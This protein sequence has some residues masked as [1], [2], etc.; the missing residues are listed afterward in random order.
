MYW[1]GI[2]LVLVI[3]LGAMDIADLLLLACL[4]VVSQLLLKSLTVKEAL[5]STRPRV[6]IM[7][8][9]SFALGS[10]LQNTGIA[11][12]VADGLVKATLS[13]G[14]CLLAS[15]IHVLGRRMDPGVCVAVRAGPF[16]VLL[17]INVA[18]SIVNGVI[19]NNACMVL[20]FPICVRVRLLCCHSS[21]HSC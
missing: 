19:S 16:A 18:T 12:W 2:S 14:A 9:A 3:I 20:M 1:S 8:A 15:S 11:D 21:A 6:L 7:I 13:G 10:A 4:T 17:G 5:E